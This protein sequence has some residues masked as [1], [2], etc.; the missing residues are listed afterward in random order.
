MIAALSGPTSGTFMKS[1]QTAVAFSLIAIA[2][3][4]SANAHAKD[5]ARTA[6]VKTAELARFAANVSADVKTLGLLLDDD[7]DYVHSNGDIDTKASFIESLNLGWRDYI[8]MEPNIQSVRFFGNL[9]IVRGTA[10]VSV[11][12][13]GTLANL[14]L[15]Y[16]DT[17]IWKDHRWQMTAWHSARY[18]PSAPAAVPA[19][20]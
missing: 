8:S 13:R 6:A 9:A 17:W 11:V 5:D 10:K 7:L 4:S 16:T 2:M 18:A 1:A 14:D 3:L 12:T 20:Q 15:G 19:A